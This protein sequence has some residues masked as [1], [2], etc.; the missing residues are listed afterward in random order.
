MFDPLGLARPVVVSAKVLLEDLWKDGLNRV[1]PIA[2]ELSSRAR[3][4]F[5]GL[6]SL[7]E[8]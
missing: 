1:D 7:Q 3:D 6:A 2:H 8:I 5:A 4:W